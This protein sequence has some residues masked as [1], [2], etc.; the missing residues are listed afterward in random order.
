MDPSFEVDCD[1]SANPPKAYLSILKKEITHLNL[2][3][4]RVDY[5]TLGYACYN[6]SD[7]QQRIIK[8]EEQSLRIDLSKTQLT[9]SE[10]SWISV[11]GCDDIMVGMTRHV[12]R[13]SVGS[14]CAAVC[15]D[16]QIANDYYAYC[17]TKRAEYWPGNGCC[18]API[19][20]GIYIFLIFQ[21]SNKVIKEGDI[22]LQEPPTWKP[23]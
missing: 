6:R 1:T 14:T 7:P 11:I 10:D 22:W 4:V 21:H 18:R 8:T 12:N 16:N 17:P 5:P 3:Q 20:K 2:S 9:L 15:K 23:I 13:T 19:P